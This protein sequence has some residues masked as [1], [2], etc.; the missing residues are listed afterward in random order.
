MTKNMELIHLKKSFS[1]RINGKRENF[2]AVDDVSFCLQKGDSLGIIGTSGCGKTTILR[3]IM[4]LLKPDSGEIKVKG[5]IG[6]VAQDPYASL[7]PSMTVFR[8]IAEPLIFTRQEKYYGN[9]VEQVKKVM[10]YVYLDFEQ[11]RN[12]LPSQLSGGERQRVSIARA[13]ILEPDILILDEPTSMLDQE[14]KDGI[15]ELIA[16]IAESGKFGFLMVTHD[17]VMASKTCASLLVMSNGKMVEKGETESILNHP[18]S[19]VTKSL[20]AV[21]TDVKEFW[22]QYYANPKGQTKAVFCSGQ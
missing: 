9:C 22:N 5:K 13:L 6:F 4:G 14:V 1:K 15:T 8:I 16:G 7:D 21:S 19:E 12:R 17:M 3:M 11:Y 18:C 20:L 2:L 10:S